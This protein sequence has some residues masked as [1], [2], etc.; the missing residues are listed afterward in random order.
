MVLTLAVFSLSC[1]G[2]G[3]T[4]PTFNGLLAMSMH[5][6]GVDDIDARYIEDYDLAQA[7]GV[8]AAQ[9]LVPWNLFEPTVGVNQTFFLTNLGYGLNAMSA[10]GL[11]ILFTFPVFDITNKTVPD[12]IIGL[13]LNDP[14]VM[15]RYRN[16]IN[17]ILPYLNSDVIYFSVGNEV[18]F[19]LA[20]NPGE[21]APYKDL[22]DNAI[23]H[24]HSVRPGMKVG[25]TT[26]FQN[27]IVEAANIATLNTNTDIHIMTYYLTD[28]ALMVTDPPSTV[29]TDLDSMVVQAAGKPLVLQ[30]IGYPSS[31]IN[32]GSEVKQAQFVEHV[33]SKWQSIGAEKLP[34]ISFFKQKDWNP[35]FC[36]TVTGGQISGEVFWEFM[37]SLGFTN[38]DLSPK[39]AWTTL[40]DQIQASNLQ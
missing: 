6:G 1:G 9:V 27:S 24:L 26:T 12:D 25:V 22:V 15:S 32:G 29:L 10:R 40:I 39:P 16:A 13:S 36:T 7:I 5:N 23:N 17:Q 34:F 20:A 30:E 33:F 19:Y 31:T 38:N 3:S 18:D 37:C 35:A 21:W 14:V 2:N 28:S 4:A 8:N 11:K